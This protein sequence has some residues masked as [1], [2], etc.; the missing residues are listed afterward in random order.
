MGRWHYSQPD[1]ILAREGNIR[2]FWKVAFRSPLV[3]D[4]DHRAVLAT[5][6]ARK[7]RWLTNYRRRRQHLPL[8]LPPEPHGE[9]T[10]TSEALKLTCQEAE[11]TK[12]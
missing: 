12:R 11:P 4:S 7:T 6:R 3:H 8:R 10:R 1:Y 9:L 2:Y 5:F